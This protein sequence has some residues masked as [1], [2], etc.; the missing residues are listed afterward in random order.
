MRGAAAGGAAGTGWA[1]AS[2]VGVA[3][4]GAALRAGW[5]AA[6]VGGAVREGAAARRFVAGAVVLA[7]AA[8]EAAGSEA[9]GSGASGSAVGADSV[10][11]SVTGSG[12]VVVSCAMSG[13]DDKA[14]T[15][16][17]AVRPERTFV[18]L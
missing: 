7:G 15:A 2:L 10:V 13:V 18:E 3:L 12:G 5:L 6:R 8:F 4:A 1:V 9:A 17:I 14:R 11:D 16:A